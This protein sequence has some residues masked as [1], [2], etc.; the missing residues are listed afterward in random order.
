MGAQPWRKKVVAPMII[1]TVWSRAIEGRCSMICAMPTIVSPPRLRVPL[2]YRRRTENVG[3]KP[4]NVAEWVRNHGGAP[5]II[6]TVWSRAIE[7]RC[8]MI[9]AMP[10]I[11]SPPI[12]LAGLVWWSGSESTFWGHNALIRIRAFAE[13]CGL[14][15]LSSA[16]RRS[17]RQ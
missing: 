8:S 17:S 13:S 7:G 5:M 11:V 16:G 14:P 9:C 15:D 4:G 3:R 1:G 12:R 2:Y 10:T 6:G